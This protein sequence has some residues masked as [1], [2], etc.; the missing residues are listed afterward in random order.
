MARLF[1][2][3]Q[4]CTANSE[5]HS[6]LSFVI[7]HRGFSCKAFRKYERNTRLQ[8]LSH[9]APYTFYQPYQAP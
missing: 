4:H 3:G 2:L 9:G 6:P 8:F 1:D 7:M 5:V